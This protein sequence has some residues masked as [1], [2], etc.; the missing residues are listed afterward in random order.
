MMDEAVAPKT[1][2]TPTHLKNNVTNRKRIFNC[3]SSTEKKVE[4]VSGTMSSNSLLLETS[5]CCTSQFHTKKPIH[6]FLSY[7]YSRKLNES[8]KVDEECGQT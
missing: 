3:I 8:K 6:G 7:V 5:V 2:I 4:C 1:Y